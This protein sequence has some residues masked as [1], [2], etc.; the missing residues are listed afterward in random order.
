MKLQKRNTPVLPRNNI[1]QREKRKQEREDR[2]V[3]K[4]VEGGPNV[5]GKCC[6]FVTQNKD[7]GVKRIAI[8]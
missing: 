4:N 1:T 3:I 7:L 5:G 6:S 8:E 2:M